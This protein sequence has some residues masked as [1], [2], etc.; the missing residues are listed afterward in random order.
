MLA[1]R[2]KLRPLL[3]TAQSGNSWR[4]DLNLYHTGEGPQGLVNLSPAWFQQ[5]HDVSPL[6]TEFNSQQLIMNQATMQ[7]CPCVSASFSSA[8]ALDWLYAIS[9]SNT[10]LSAVLAVIHPNLYEA[11]WNTINHLRHISETGS[12]DVL[13]RWAS[14]FSS[15]AVISNRDTPPHRDGSSRV[16]WYDILVT[17]YQENVISLE[18]GLE[19]A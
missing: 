3:K 5:G 2:E 11:S 1:A 16:N 17:L 4:D 8:A 7:Q 6:R 9:E 10:I 13:S 18:N 15:V 14:V 19:I 12:R